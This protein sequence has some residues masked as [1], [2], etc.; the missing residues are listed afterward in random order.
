MVLLTKSGHAILDISGKGDPKPYQVEHDMLFE[1]IAK[2]DYKYADAENGAKSTM[3]SILGR[4]A[5]Y[6]GQLVK[7]DE[8]IASTLDLSPKKYD[9]NANPQVMP[10]ENGFYPAIIPGITQVM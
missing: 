3:T 2:G 6:S 5:T 8:A 4:M 7:W 9:W 1:A 10:D